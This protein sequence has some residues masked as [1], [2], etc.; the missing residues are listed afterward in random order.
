MKAHKTRLV[1]V[2]QKKVEKKKTNLLVPSY[3]P[4]KNAELDILLKAT[5]GHLAKL[6][7]SQSCNR[8]D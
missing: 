1:A 2:S 8:V 7:F 5:W 4:E 3:T 6:S